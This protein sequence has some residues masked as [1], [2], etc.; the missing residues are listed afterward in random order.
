MMFMLL[1][2]L[3]GLASFGTFMALDNALTAPVRFVVSCRVVCAVLFACQLTR[4]VFLC[5]RLCSRPWRAL[6]AAADC[7][8]TVISDVL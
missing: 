4:N 2:L 8:A 7:A 6:T 3:V 1:P 5:C